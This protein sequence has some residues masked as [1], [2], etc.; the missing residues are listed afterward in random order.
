LLAGC[1]ARLSEAGDA[2]NAGEEDNS[3]EPGNYFL[4]HWEIDHETEYKC[5]DD[6]AI[7]NK[8]YE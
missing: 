8:I 3:Q 4:L 2:P 7:K 6:R 1:A 5:K